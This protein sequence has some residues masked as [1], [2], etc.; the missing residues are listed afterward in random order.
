MT[1]R[2]E[3]VWLRIRL[4]VAA[5]AYEIENQTIMPD[6]EFD[7]MCLRV[8]PE[9]TTGNRKLDNFFKK[10]FDPCTG[11]WVRKHPEPRKLAA[12]LKQHFS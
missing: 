9:I 6:G 7:A 1:E 11:C 12:I 8:K 4:S 3:Q 2:E 5:Y 10:H